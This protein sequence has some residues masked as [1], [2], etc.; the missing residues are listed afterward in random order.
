MHIFARDLEMPETVSLEPNKRMGYRA[1]E[2][3]DLENIM[4]VIHDAQRTMGEAGLDQWQDGY[5]SEEVILGDIRKG[6]S[7]IWEEEGKILGTAMLSF[8]GESDY[9]RIYDGEWKL[10]EVSY[11]TIHRIAVLSA[12]RRRGTAGKLL[13]AMEEEIR[14]NGFSVIRMDTHRDN[15]P[16]RTWLGSHGFLHCGTI[17]LGRTEETRLAFEKSLSGEK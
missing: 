15:V 12:D 2:E 7:R 16:M 9:D 8:R 4:A 5:P 14:K 17:F 3:K 6:E 13:K 1:G 11:A 10:G